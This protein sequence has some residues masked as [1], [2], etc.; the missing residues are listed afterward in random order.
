MSSK[1]STPTPITT[2]LL[3]AKNNN[4]GTITFNFADGTKQH[5]SINKEMFFD[6]KKNPLDLYK[7]VQHINDICHDLKAVDYEIN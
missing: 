5:Q 1:T 3:N 6:E 7:V 2:A 4:N